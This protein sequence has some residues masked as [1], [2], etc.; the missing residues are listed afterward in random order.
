MAKA[1]YIYH[2]TA[3]APIKAWTKG[4]AMQGIASH[5]GRRPSPGR[6]PLGNR[7]SGRAGEPAAGES[8]AGES[9]GASES[10]DDA[11]QDPRLPSYPAKSGHDLYGSLS[12]ILGIIPKVLINDP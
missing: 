7:R 2:Q 6:K 10:L 12:L 11:P 5:A 9:V 1:N 8:A 3:G 4:V